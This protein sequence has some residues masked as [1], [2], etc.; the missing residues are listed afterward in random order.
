MK[1]SYN[2]RILRVTE[3]KKREDVTANLVAENTYFLNQPIAPLIGFS[4][5]TTS[6]VTIKIQA[7]RGGF[8]WENI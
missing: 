4:L 1:S 6:I 5:D 8:G 7:Q 3:F 2:F